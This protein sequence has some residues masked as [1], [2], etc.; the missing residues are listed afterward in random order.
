M[1]T[2]ANPGERPESDFEPGGLAF[3]PLPACHLLVRRSAGVAG[4]RGED[5]VH[6]ARKSLG[7][8]LCRIING[9]LRNE[10]LN[11]EIFE[12]LLE[13]RVLIERWGLVMRFLTGM[14]PHFV[15]SFSRA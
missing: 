10:G 8:R 11:G 5:A 3:E 12:T 14:I 15:S 2:A 7:K 1:R 13:A 6:R 4:S 9:K